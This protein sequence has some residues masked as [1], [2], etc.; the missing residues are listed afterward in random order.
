MNEQDIKD[1]V[2]KLLADGKE[3]GTKLIE[4]IE[5]TAKEYI[6]VV[7]SKIAAISKKIDWKFTTKIVL[8]ILAAIAIAALFYGV[9]KKPSPIT[10]H[11]F[12]QTQQMSEVKNLDKVPVAPPT[13]IY[14]YPKDKV[15]KKVKL[16]DEVV[17]DVNKKIV[18]TAE[19]PETKAGYDIVAVLDNSTGKVNTIAKEKE[20]PY[21]QLRNDLSVGVRGGV[22]AGSPVPYGGDIHTQWTFL[23]IKKATVSAYGEAGFVD[24]GYAKAMI[25]VDYS[26]TK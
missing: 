18:D 12:A 5:A 16:P 23:R 8:G 22:V 4:N 7:E 11:E 25:A 17:N 10:T 19:V 2:A 24:K 14:I 13:V 1:L 3:E 6:P 9:F 21:F 20:L 26:I 15:V